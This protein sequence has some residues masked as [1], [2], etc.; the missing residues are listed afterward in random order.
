DSPRSQT[1]RLS[2]PD[3]ATL[4]PTDDGGAEVTAHEEALLAIPPP[5]AIDATGAKVP[6]TLTVSGDTIT[7]SV[8]PDDSARLPILLD[9][10]FQ[11]YQSQAGGNGNGIFYST[12]HE[13]WSPET[14]KKGG[15]LPVPYE[16]EAPFYSDYNGLVVASKSGG[17][18]SGD[19]GA[20]IYTVPRYFSDQQQYGRRPE[21]FITHMTLSNL[22]WAAHSETLSPYV[23]AGLWDS[24]TGWVTYYSH[25]GLQGHGVNEPNWQYQFPPS[26]SNTDANVKVASVGMWALENLK[27]AGAA[28]VEVGA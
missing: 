6:T 21:S 27:S 28:S 18:S 13:E 22:I 9:P 10:L 17:A 2:F 3:D 20:W 16:P 15:G 14:V 5:T 23:F 8:L 12:A 25:E 1:F 11:S 24:N 26:G 19:H 7:V 4:R